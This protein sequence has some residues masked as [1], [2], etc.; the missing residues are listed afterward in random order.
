[1]RVRSRARR[2]RLMTVIVNIV[3]TIIRHSHY[4]IILFSSRRL[5]LFIITT[6]A[7]E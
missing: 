4:I 3:A 5:H 2:G 7:T 1:M 6:T